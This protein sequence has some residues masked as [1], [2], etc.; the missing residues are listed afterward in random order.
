MRRVL[1]F[2]FAQAA[3]QPVADAQT[4]WGGGKPW[5]GTLVVNEYVSMSGIYAD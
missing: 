5:M 3:Q 1:I 4:C 2:C